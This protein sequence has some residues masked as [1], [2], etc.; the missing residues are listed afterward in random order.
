MISFWFSEF[1]GIYQ[2]LLVFVGRGWAWF[3]GI[4]AWGARFKRF[5]GCE[6]VG[7]VG[8]KE[9]FWVVAFLLFS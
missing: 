8:F 6:L 7:R 3:L 1:M 9:P 5:L 4:G 2:L